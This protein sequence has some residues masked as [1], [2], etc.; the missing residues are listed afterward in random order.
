MLG[1]S[2][3]RGVVAVFLWVFRGAS[4]MLLYSAG[5]RCIRWDV[6]AFRGGGFRVTLGSPAV[7]LREA[8]GVIHMPWEAGASKTKR[9]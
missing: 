3:V 8:F 4:G 9:G 6:A 7:Y 5:C 1:I 2:G